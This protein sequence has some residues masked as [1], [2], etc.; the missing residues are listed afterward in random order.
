L[1]QAA[2]LGGM[3]PEAGLL[4]GEALHELGRFDEAEHVLSAASAEDTPDG[5]LRV[6]LTE[7][8]SRNLMWGL[9]RFEDALAVNHAGRV[10]LED[11]ADVEELDLNQALLLVYSGRPLDALHVLAPIADPTRPRARALKALAEVP[12]LVATGRCERATDEAGRAF[13]EHSLLP[14][15][16]AIPGPGVHL[17]TQV[18]ALAEC[19]RLAEASALAMAAYEATPANAPPDALIWFA[20][21]L[22]RCA[23][24]A[25]QPATARRWLAEALARCEAYDLVSAHRLVLSALATAHA[26]LGDGQAAAAAVQELDRCPPHP[27][28]ASEHEMGRAWASATAGDLP[29]ARQILRAAAETAASRGYRMSEAW[30]LHDVARLGDPSAV[31]SRLA[32]LAG[33]CEGGLVAAYADH[34]AARTAAA[35]VDV[36]DRF[37]AMG[38]LLLAAEVAAESSQAYQREGDRRASAALGV[39]ASM[40]ARQCEGA[41][42]PGLTVPV[43]VVPLTARERDIAVLA[44]QGDSSKEIAERLFLSVRTVDN[45]LQNVYSKLG[46]SGRRQLS[47]ALAD[48]HVSTAAGGP[49]PPTASSRR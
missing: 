47:A 10:P 33:E 34:T 8:R 35:L 1:G 26:W 9:L 28:V 45:H 20:H 13:A 4:V 36:T 2:L 39:R 44:A 29:G 15:Q 46:V 6:Q 42:T 41:R 31:A 24:L 5:A 43:I 23:L 7:I 14:E 30:L 12:A 3:T 48:R 38:A 27:F 40:L 16:I 25:G 37:E 21:Q 11:P 18:Y 17:V 49:S 22:G 32:E 19:G